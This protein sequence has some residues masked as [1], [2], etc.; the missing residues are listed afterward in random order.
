[1]EDIS[2]SCVSLNVAAS[3]EKKRTSIIRETLYRQLL[4]TSLAA[5]FNI[6]FGISLA[7]SAILNPE[8]GRNT[9]DIQTTQAERSWVASV[10]TLA[11]PVGAP[12]GGILMDTVGRLNTVKI[13]CVPAVIGWVLIATSSNFW[14]LIVGRICTG[15]ASV[16][17][18][19][20][21]IVYITE[22]ARSD[23]RGSLIS[24]APAYTSLGMVLAYIKG[25][26]FGWRLTAWL[27]GKT[28]AELQFINLKEA[29]NKKRT[30]DHHK[31]GVMGVLGG[32]LKPT[33]Y[34]P[35]LILFGF[36][37]FQQFSGI[38]ITL[39]YSVEFFDEV[40]T[41]INPYLCSI[42]IGMVRAVMSVVNTYMLK[43]FRRR[44]LLI[45][46]SLGMALSMFISGLFTTWIKNGTTT[47]NWIPVV[48]VM[49]YVVASM[50]GLL[51]IPWTMTAEL[52][53]I[54]IRAVAHSWIYSGAYLIMFFS[55]Q[56]YHALEKLCGGVAEVQWFF[57]VVSMAGLVYAVFFL[58]ETHGSEL[59]EIEDYFRS[60]TIYLWRKTKTPASRKGSQYSYRKPSGDIVKKN[61][62]KTVTE[63]TTDQN[64]KLLSQS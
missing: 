52:F 57:G 48:A 10:L 26:A 12:V 54:E 43:T 33:G 4:A 64:E 51:S 35:L 16:W 59:S 47:W 24:F 63:D 56:N 23:I 17:G 61:V 38:Y 32:F 7:Y 13:A 44:P 30:M 31:R 27:C 1:M 19:G 42:F 8:L 5:S 25:W 6:V 36:F 34:K 62:L 49:F 53:P 14:T 2:A 37:I 60:N 46:S 39:F 45:W 28:L 20:P 50:F 11:V 15:V 41:N 18:T 58:P 29:N 22:I 21:A 40:G 55:V 3:T 9:S